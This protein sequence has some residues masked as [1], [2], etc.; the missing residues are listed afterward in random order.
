VKNTP[1]RDI[2][3]VDPRVGLSGVHFR[4]GTSI[5]VSVITM[6]SKR[7]SPNDRSF[8]R[9]HAVAIALG[10]G[11]WRTKASVLSE[12]RGD[13]LVGQAHGTPLSIDSEYSVHSPMRRQAPHR[14]LAAAS[15][16]S[17][18]ETRVAGLARLY[19]TDNVSKW[20]SGWPLA[21]PVTDFAVI[22]KV[23]CEY[24]NTSSC[25]WLS[26]SAILAYTLARV[27]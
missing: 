15:L 11:N 17:P 18:C 27:V 22:E 19:L 1:C 20:S 8:C 23:G 3:P 9:G 4:W 14:V 25:C 16:R 21:T 24:R 13:R 26:R 12:Q 7:T 6:K 2:L 10:N 5:T